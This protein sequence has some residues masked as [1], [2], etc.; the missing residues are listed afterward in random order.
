MVNISEDD[1]QEIK[2][3]KILVIITLIVI[4]WFWIWGC[5]MLFLCI[6]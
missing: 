4:V 2:L 3:M 6:I 5:D 1:K